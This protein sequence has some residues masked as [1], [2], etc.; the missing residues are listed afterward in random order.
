[1]VM[2]VRNFQDHNQ[3]RL[4][5]NTVLPNYPDSEILQKLN[6]RLAP[7]ESTDT[8]QTDVTDKGSDLIERS[9]YSSYQGSEYNSEYSSEYYSMPDSCG[10]GPSEEE[11]K[12]DMAKHLRSTN[13]C[14]QRLDIYFL[15]MA[16]QDPPAAPP[17]DSETI[18]SAWIT[19]PTHI[20][21]GERNRRIRRSSQTP[22]VPVTQVPSDATAVQEKLKRTASW[23]TWQRKNIVVEVFAHEIE[24]AFSQRAK[25]RHRH[26]PS[27]KL[28]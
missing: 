11:I 10:P 23:S 7:W 17:N 28:T 27:N 9:A 24:Y 4:E 6:A 12:N 19:A 20:F 13:V 2:D 26:R 8:S 14:I 25:L 22:L 16:L 5:K 1:M 15:F 18:T 21:R 3:E